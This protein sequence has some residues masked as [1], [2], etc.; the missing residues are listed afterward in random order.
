MPF[1]DTVQDYKHSAGR[2]L[3]DAKELLEVPTLDPQRSDAGSRH[4]RGAM[5]LAGYAV[6]CLVKAYFVQQRNAQT[7]AAAVEAL[8]RQRQQQGKEPVDQIARTAAG[9][10]IQYLLQLTNLPQY[11]AYDAKLWARVAQ[12]RSSWRYETDLV[13]RS[14]AQQFISDVQ[15][16]VNWVSP[17]IA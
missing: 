3:E 1:R 7:L 10:K 5:Y 13:A 12:W 11:P 2:R 9:H 15:D 8:N 17:K 16:V 4:L 14:D 6:E